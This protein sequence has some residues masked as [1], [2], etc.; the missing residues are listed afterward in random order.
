MLSEEIRDR[1]KE[2]ENDFSST[3]LWYLAFNL[4]Q[5]ASIFHSQGMKVGDIRPENVFINEE[6]LTKVAN[7]YSWPQEGA[8]Y[9]KSYSEK[10]VTYLGI[11]V[12]R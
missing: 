11:I 7:L 2:R 3:E 10:Q 8:N 1:V 5:S 9:D 4:L 12:K 6:G